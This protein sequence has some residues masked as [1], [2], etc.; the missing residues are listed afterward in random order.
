[1]EYKKGGKSYD[2]ECK[3]GYA[4]AGDGCV[5]RV[6][7]E[8]FDSSIPTTGRD[9][10]TYRSLQLADGELDAKEPDA[11]VSAVFRHYLV[12][13]GVGCWKDRV[14]RHCQVLANLCVLTLY[15]QASPACRFLK[16]YMGEGS[17]GNANWANELREG[18]PWIQYTGQD[19]STGSGKATTLLA[20]TLASQG[21]NV[22]PAML[23]D[24]SNGVSRHMKFQLGQYALN[25]T[26][27]GFTELGS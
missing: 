7:L 20:E 23:D 17:A 4:A 25:G 15:D 13:A 16:E 3:A 9:T 18:L 24:K 8:A 6:D 27:L 26:W 19:D 10:I 22:V 14:P 5:N 12:E 2:C 21:Y 11:V 1:M